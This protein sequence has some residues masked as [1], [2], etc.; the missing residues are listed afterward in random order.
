MVST[1]LC[2]KLLI[3]VASDGWVGVKGR[4][5]NVKKNALLVK[6]GFP[7]EMQFP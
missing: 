4:L 1:D 3:F 5:K 7:K 6:D 2:L